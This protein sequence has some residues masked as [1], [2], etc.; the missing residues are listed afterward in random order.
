MGQYSFNKHKAILFDFG[1]TLDSDGGHWLD[2]FYRIYVDEGVEVSFLKLK[3]AFYYADELCCKDPDV[4]NFGLNTLLK[5]HVQLQFEKLGLQFYPKG[6]AISKSF[7]ESMLYYLKRNSTLLR[8]L[9][10]HYK[11]GIVSNFYGNLPV[12]LDQFGIYK[13][14]DVVIDSERVGVRKP[15]PSIFKIAMDRIDEPASS[16]VFVGDSYERDIMP[17][18]SLGMR[19]IWMKGPNPRV[20]EDPPDV[21]AVITNLIQLKDI[22]L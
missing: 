20:P 4:N 5:H 18:K 22:F 16:V 6:I 12:I 1:G 19:V 11:L 2:R 8:K 17:C 10:L 21:D 15:D 3:E 13:L 9:R 7:L 14:L